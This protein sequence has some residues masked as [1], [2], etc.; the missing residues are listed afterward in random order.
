[1]QQ[2]CTSIAL[3]L[4][5]LSPSMC[6]FPF[7]VSPG[8]VFLSLPHFPSSFPFLL[9]PSH[10]WR[11]RSLRA[12]IH[13]NDIRNI[14]NGADVDRCCSKRVTPRWPPWFSRTPSR[15]TW[16]SS[17]PSQS[18]SSTCTTTPLAQRCK[19]I[20]PS[21]L[22]T[23]STLGNLVA[24]PIILSPPPP[25]PDAFPDLPRMHSSVLSLETDA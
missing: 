1:M 2:S 11:T 17:T 21:P 4:R 7:H 8:Y 25:P 23:T 3:T 5:L 10:S 12:T 18:P 19:S 20:E 13:T 15:T 14:T 16:T 9:H 22:P 6:G 24:S